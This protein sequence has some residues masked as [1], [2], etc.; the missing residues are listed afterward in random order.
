MEHRDRTAL[1]TGAAFF[2]SEP[3]VAGRP[4]ALGADE[5][6][7]AR[8]RRLDVG[9]QVRLVDG[10]GAIGAGTIVRLGRTVATVDVATVERVEPPPP[11]HILAPIADRDRV[12]WLA[13]KAS[14]LAVTSWR[15]V[16]W[17]RSR[18]V[19]PRGEGVAF[20]AKVRARMVAALKQ[21]GGA[22]L[23]EIHPD[24]PPGRAIHA[25]PAG[26]RLLLHHSGVPILSQPLAAPVTVAL[27][28]EGG[29][30]PEEHD[31]LL[32]AGFVPARLADAV[33]RFETAG[34]VA[35][36]TLRAA[37]TV[38]EEISHG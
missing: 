5:A 10:A 28:P 3:L 26:M 29:I 14:E 22:W 36:G 1:A 20:Q 25:A 6:A 18:S 30:E 13:E 35:L 17:H 24:A 38:A 32:A 34:V 7:H 12:L 33:L 21:S 15:P 11:I 27:G 4:A 8:V 9:S 23:P 2:V 19:S 16:L 31:A 37:L